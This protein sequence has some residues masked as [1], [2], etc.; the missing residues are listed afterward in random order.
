MLSSIQ[1]F[2]PNQQ[3]TASLGLGSWEQPLQRVHERDCLSNPTQSPALQGSPSPSPAS[4]G[5]TSGMDSSPSALALCNPPGFLSASRL[6]H[7][8]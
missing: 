6:A 1:G 7:V 2:V 4:P 3:V 5:R 8:L